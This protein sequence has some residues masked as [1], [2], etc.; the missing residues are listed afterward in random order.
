MAN[1][2]FNLV[3]AQ[4]DAEFQLKCLLISAVELRPILF[5]KANVNFYQRDM[6]ERVWGEVAEIV[7]RDGKLSFISYKTDFKCKVTTIIYLHEQLNKLTR[8]Y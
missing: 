7:G 4:N 8:I 3:D 6:K 5:D 1:L 2:N